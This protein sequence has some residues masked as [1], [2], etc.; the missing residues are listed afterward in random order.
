METLYF[1]GKVE[2]PTT[3]ELYEHYL[4]QAGTKAL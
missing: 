2:A 3:K 4:S 1:S